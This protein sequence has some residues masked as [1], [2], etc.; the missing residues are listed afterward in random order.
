[1]K[2]AAIKARL[3]KLNISMENLEINNDEIEV[4]VGYVEENGRGSC[5]DSKTNRLANKIK[6][7][8]PE[9]TASTGTGYGAI[10]IHFNFTPC[11]LRT[12]N[13]D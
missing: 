12:Q 4:C 2:A 6:K 13:I 9:C 11:P 7:H 3:K 1:M 10:I 8:F 5:D